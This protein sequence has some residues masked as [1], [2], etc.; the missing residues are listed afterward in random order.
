[1]RY[2][3][4]FQK[5]D[6]DIMVLLHSYKLAEITRIVVWAEIEGRRLSLPLPPM[7][8]KNIKLL[9]SMNLR[10]DD[11]SDSD[12]IRWLK[13]INPGCVGIVLKTLIRR[14]MEKADIRVFMD[15]PEKL[16]VINREAKP[17]QRFEPIPTKRIETDV[18]QSFFPEVATKKET[19]Y[20]TIIEPDDEMV[21]QDE[22][23]NSDRDSLFNLI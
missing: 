19:V 1:M 15:S 21:N 18:V 5:N 12:V 22:K 13:E 20:E 23:S 7:P 2:H 9:R 4:Y 14:A 8:A 11:V 10:L 16:T 6:L 17:K 3:I